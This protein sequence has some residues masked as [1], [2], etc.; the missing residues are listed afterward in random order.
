MNNLKMIDTFAKRIK[1]HDEVTSLMNKIETL[2]ENRDKMSEAAFCI[3]SR[4]ILTLVNNVSPE[5]D[6]KEEISME[7]IG[8]TIVTII[9]AIWKQI[10]KAWEWLRAKA[11]KIWELIT[12]IFKKHEVVVA[13]N[14]TYIDKISSDPTYLFVLDKAILD[15]GLKFGDKVTTDAIKGMKE[16]M[17]EELSGKGYD[18]VNLYILIDRDNVLVDPRE[19]SKNATVLL[20]KSILKDAG[21]LQALTTSDSVATSDIGGDLNNIKESDTRWLAYLQKMTD[22]ATAIANDVK[23][24]KETTLDFDADLEEYKK[25]TNG[26]LL[27][28]K[29]HFGRMGLGNSCFSVSKENSIAK[30]ANSRS[31]RKY[32][33]SAG[34]PIKSMPSITLE[35]IDSV[36][37]T[38]GL[39]INENGKSNE[40]LAK[41]TENLSKIVKELKDKAE[42]YSDAN[43]ATVLSL[44]RA[45]KEIV[46]SNTR[47]TRDYGTLYGMMEK[48]VVG[49]VGEPMTEQ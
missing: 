2:V 22:N 23:L 42:T 33:E 32:D 10:L 40:A 7:G 19:V 39:V 28:G 47:R 36:Y 16:Q 9:Q 17:V 34:R 24:G 12:G 6:Q 44:S 46:D 43:K 5:W 18:T 38:L 29:Y 14:L 49:I 37:K 20:P 45:L 13:S 27:N 35:D 3:R 21:I 4:T 1:E 25:L 31:N 30:I 41:S 8:E 11:A 26:M 48:L 15:A